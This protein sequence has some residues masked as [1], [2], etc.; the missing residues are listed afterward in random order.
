MN[1][2]GAVSTTGPLYQPQTIDCGAI[3][4]MEIRKENLRTGRKPAL[5]PLCPPQI[6]H[7][8]TRTPMRTAVVGSQ[9]LTAW[10]M[11]RPKLDLTV[12]SSLLIWW[13]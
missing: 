10:A 4:G 5:A 8:E 13:K 3:G 11:A 2:H 9:R 1:S 6:P 7:D 12:V